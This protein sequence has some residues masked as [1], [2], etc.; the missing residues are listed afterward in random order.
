MSWYPDRFALPAFDRYTVVPTRVIQQVAV[1]PVGAV[2]IGRS[3]ASAR[4]ASLD[5][6]PP[7]LRHETVRRVIDC[8]VTDLLDEARRRLAKLDPA[9]ADAIRRAKYPVIGFGSAM[10]E[11]NR[12]IKDFLMTRMYH[13]W[14]VNRMT[15]KARL[16]TEDL[17]R[18]LHA[19]PTLLA[20]DWRARAGEA[21]SGRAAAIVCDY[22][23]GM[24]DRYAID[25]HRRLT[26]LS[27]PG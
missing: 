22:I 27:V 14:R 8:M 9:D 26:N 7:R 13:H 5:V 10:A 15:R 17:F 6:P 11:A 21:G 16:L 3:V 2:A 23:A 4:I 1:W 19:D 24:T 25:E 20:D 18:V 12:A